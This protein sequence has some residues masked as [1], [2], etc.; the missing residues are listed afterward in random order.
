MKDSIL[1]IRISKEEKDRFFKAC[2]DH[3]IKPSRQ[4]RCMIQQLLERSE[5]D[6]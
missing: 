2:Q 4:I 5:D 1:T 6:D 3:G